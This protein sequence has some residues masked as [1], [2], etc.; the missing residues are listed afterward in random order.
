LSKVLLVG[1]S[2]KW[3]LG[4]LLSGLEWEVTCIFLVTC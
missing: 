3:H 1:F 4:L 2:H